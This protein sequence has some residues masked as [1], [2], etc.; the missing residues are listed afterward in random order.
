MS[1]PL[2]RGGLFADRTEARCADCRHRR[3]LRGLWSAEARLRG[4]SLVG[5]NWDVWFRV[6]L[7]EVGQD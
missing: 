2:G 1:S 5:T 6:C 3:R 7:I 4:P